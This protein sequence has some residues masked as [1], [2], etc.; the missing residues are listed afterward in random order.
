MDRAPRYARRVSRIGALAVVLGLSAATVNSL[1]P[2]AADPTPGPAPSS[3]DVPGVE[4]PQEPSSPAGSAATESDPD[5]PEFGPAEAPDT[6]GDQVTVSV[7]DS[8][9]VTYGSSGGAITS[10][11]AKDT[12]PT[13]EAAPSAVTPSA[14]APPAPV[15][16]S[17]EAAPKPTAVTRSL[18]ARLDKAPQSTGDPDGSDFVFDHAESA[19][20]VDASATSPLSLED[21]GTDRGRFTVILT[22]RY[23]DVAPTV[24]LRPSPGVPP[25]ADV[26][27]VPTAPAAVGIRA[28]PGALINAAS[29]V[30][31]AALSPFVVPS[32]DLPVDSPVLWALLAWVRRHFADQAIPVTYTAPDADPRLGRVKLTLDEAPLSA[33]GT[34]T[35][36]GAT[37]TFLE[38]LVALFTRLVQGGL[39]ID[40]D[41]PY[42]LDG[43][44]R[45][46]GAVTGSVNVAAPGGEPPLYAMS[47]APTSGAAS[48]DPLTGNWTFTP[49]PASRV[50]AFAISGAAEVTFAVIASLGWAAA[51]PI[52]V[53]AP[54]H[55]AE[56][57]AYPALNGVPV[58]GVRLASNDIGF[59][60]LV[61]PDPVAATYETAVAII[62]PASPTATVTAPVAGALSRFVFAPDHTAYSTTVVAHAGQDVYAMTII[63]PSGESATMPIVGVPV[64]DVVFGPDGRA[65]Q[66]SYRHDAATDTYVTT[67]TVVDADARRVEVPVDGH[68]AGF[69]FGADGAV[70]Q[71][72][73]L[74]PFGPDDAD[75]KTT[76]AVIDPAAGSAT[77]VAQIPGAALEFAPAPDGA[78]VQTTRTAGVHGYAYTLTRIVNHAEPQ[79][80]PLSG[81]VVGAIGFTPTGAAALTV[82]TAAPHETPG[83]VVVVDP[84]GHVTQI[85]L[86]ARPRGGIEVGVDGTARQGVRGGDVVLIDVDAAAVIDVV[87]AHT[88]S[89]VGPDGTVYTHHSGSARS[90]VELLRSDGTAAAIDAD[91]A[92]FTGADTSTAYS[93]MQGVQFAPDGTPYLF[94]GIREATGFNPFFGDYDSLCVAVIDAAAGTATHLPVAG[95]DNGFLKFLS[96]NTFAYFAPTV[97]AAAGVQT[98]VTFVDLAAANAATVRID[99]YFTDYVVGADGTSYIVTNTDFDAVG[100]TT[101]R[102]YAMTVASADG[103]MWTTT[104]IEGTPYE[105][106]VTGPDGAVYQVVESADGV[107]A[108][109]IVSHPGSLTFMRVDLDGYPQS[110]VVFDSA[111]TGYVTTG[112]VDP[113]EGDLRTVVTVVAVPAGGAVA[114]EPVAT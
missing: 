104:P 108:G 58:R 13:T 69:G 28:L 30:L 66:T 8:P 10:G 44:D 1:H 80:I 85:A 18:G 62:D 39:L 3:P 5:G 93:V 17:V 82:R 40:P 96:D 71:V 81:A 105:T 97:D 90:V 31:T 92:L 68:P 106:M 42:T 84:A 107:S 110:P 12:A 65:Y 114:P 23:S 79:A 87:A 74:R 38:D 22:P 57:A 16:A 78:V 111:G 7:G 89:V 45:R 100:G 63:R 35:A 47:A 15:A 60:V 4:S 49:T 98:A 70:Y 24:V 20:T 32:P 19:P 29:G 2:A 50:Q 103:A 14:I 59:Q 9:P 36:A 77:V 21:M 25:D 26:F 72:T 41:R 67:V 76:V 43:V 99:G 53:P 34:S 83:E 6:G 61:R 51:G 27:A 113:T 88:A 95:G 37:R 54:V 52:V 55:G 33:S 91:G 75:N 11:T 48:V 46:S 86:P 73:E 101:G 112:T 94:A 109:V 102:A 64:G 56:T